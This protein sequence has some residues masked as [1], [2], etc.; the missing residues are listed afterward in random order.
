MEETLSLLIY[1]YIKSQKNIDH[2]FVNESLRVA[3][4][5]YHLED[6]IT[7]IKPLSN[8]KIYAQYSQLKKTIYI[9]YEKTYEY[10]QKLI[11]I[12]SL[13]HNVPITYQYIIF[14]QILLHEVMH[15]KQNKQSTEYSDCEDI[16]FLYQNFNITPSPPNNKTS[17]E[18][19]ILYEEFNSFD[20]IAKDIEDG[21]IGIISGFIKGYRLRKKYI[22]LYE[23]SP[24]ER[25]ANIDS[26][27]IASNIAKLLNDEQTLIFLLIQNYQAYL[28]GYNPTIPQEKSIEP[29]K[30]Y[31]DA[32]GRNG[33][34]EDILK[35]SSSLSET[36][37]IRLGLKT[38]QEEL[39]KIA[40][41]SRQLQLTLFK[42]S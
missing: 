15:A 10:I 7:S 42:N 8:P 36:E 9:N 21:T 1:D 28:C 30:Y 29:T 4:Q 35:L 24:A 25:L 13:D 19:I 22:K 16:S 31:L 34:W 2:F 20:N 5:Y 26:T 33:K 32:I 41:K 17:A 38:N 18:S 3:I 27:Q 37:K 14:I 39:H 12:T 23:Y 6:Y 40:K 11:K